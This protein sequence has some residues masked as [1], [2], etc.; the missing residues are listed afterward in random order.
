MYWL[1]GEKGVT[2]SAVKPIVHYIT[3][4]TEVY[5]LVA[6]EED[7]G[8]TKE[9]KEHMKVNLQLRYSDPHLDQLLS[10]ASFLNPRFK[11][12]YVGDQL[13]EC[14]RRSERSANP[15]SA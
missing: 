1:H 14:P 10:L 12:C 2:V 8:L 9:M 13:G 15:T 11:L 5:I 4:V 7:T 3:T 6:K